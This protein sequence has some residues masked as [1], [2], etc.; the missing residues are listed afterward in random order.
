MK[1]SN[2][3]HLHL[4]SQYSILDG[5][6]KFPD[7]MNKAK[8]YGMRTVALTDHGNLHGAIEFYLTAIKNGIKPIIG[9]ECYVAPSSRFEKRKESGLDVYAF[10]LILLAMNEEGLR[11][12]YKISSTGYTEG[13]YHKPRVDKEI[14]E[15]YNG[16]L[17]AM[18]A[19]LQGE[20]PYY[21]LKGEDEKAKE[22]ADFFKSTFGKERFYLEIMDNGLKEQKRANEKILSLAKNMD[23]EVV[24]SADVHF[25]SKEDSLVHEVILCIQTNKKIDDSDRFRF[26]SDQFYFKA[27]EE[28]E[29]AFGH[30]PSALKNTLKIADMCNVNIEFDKPHFPH[31][32]IPEGKTKSRLFEKKVQQGFEKRIEGKKKRNEKIDLETYNQRLKYEMNMIKKLG[33]EEYFLI[34][35]DIV[36]Y[37]RNKGIPV[38]PGRGSAAGSFVSYCLGITQIDPL[39]YGLVFERFLNP[40][41]VTLPDIDVDFCAERRDE[42]IEYVRKRF[43]EDRVAF[44]GTF[45]NIKARQAVRDVCRVFGLSSSRTDSIAKLIPKDVNVSLKQAV[46]E[47]AKLREIYK[48]DEEIKKIF[49]MAMKI[50]FVVRQAGTHAGGV[51]ITPKAFTE[52]LP[53]FSGK[54]KK[55]TTQF[56]KDILDKMGYIKFDFL[57]LNTITAIYETVNLIKE[58]RNI[59][60]NPEDIPFDDE[61]TFKMLCNGDTQ[62]V[63][64]LSKSK[65]MIALVRRLKPSR[66]EDIIAVLALHRPGPLQSGW[67]DTYIKRKQGIEK[68]EYPFPSLEDILKE[69][70]GIILYQEQVMEIARVLSGFTMAEAD[71]LRYAIGKKVQEQMEVMEEKFINGAVSRGYDRDKVE[72]LFSNIRN[73]AQYSFNKSHSTA[74]AYLA[75]WTAYLKAHYPVEFF[76]AMLNTSLGKPD[77]L[78]KYINAARDAGIEILPPDVNKSMPKFTIENGKIRFC[79]TGIKNVG[80]NAVDEILSKR[81]ENP[82]TSIVDFATRVN[83]R[84][85]NKRVFESLVKAG[86]FDF[87]GLKR[88][89]IFESIDEIIKEAAKLKSPEGQIE[90]FSTG[91]LKGEV[92]YEPMEEWHDSLKLKYEKEVLGVYLSGHP[93]QNVW[94]SVSPFVNATAE[95]VAEGNIETEEVVVA[96][97]VVNYSK[98]KSKKGNPFAIMTIEDLTG[99]IDVFMFEGLMN[100]LPEEVEDKIFIV[101]GTMDP[102]S[103]NKSRILASDVVPV[104]KAKKTFAKSAHIKINTIGLSDKDIVKLRE[105]TDRYKGNLKT[106]IYLKFPQDIEVVLKLSRHHNLKM[107]EELIKEMKKEFDAELFYST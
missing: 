86:A 65:S 25:I 4:H 102:E 7:L 55:P 61:V 90:I 64:Q 31:Y 9:L 89:Q 70:Y 54:D 39:K 63:F 53:I 59:E 73:F 44:V 107:S 106:Y 60:I 58:T 15:K 96:G 45:Q 47:D 49:D 20:I 85:I 95:D 3:V 30:L 26:N 41:R 92:N 97:V 11:N 2:F 1:K 52:E 103:G 21:L 62:G 38:G 71:T 17:I 104:N 83:A 68:T 42:V 101:K 48:S 36:N 13:F 23:I 27:P 34:V 78:I 69:T 98:R 105:M 88:S 56:N 57:A 87:T 74:Y 50:E 91:E 40:D 28:M 6:I 46:K 82:Y 66:F 80:V 10:H 22:C 43:G 93:L 5:F 8:E 81:K 33:F 72:K 77:D 100:K 84:K 32:V 76:T 14:I 29:K 37:A 24:A 94:E 99:T 19:C 35:A 51:V 79:L 16:G 18:S 12:L 67:A 75:Y